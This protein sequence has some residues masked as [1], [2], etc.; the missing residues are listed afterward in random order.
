MKEVRHRRR[1]SAWF[2]LNTVPRQGKQIH[3]LEYW[4]P[5]GEWGQW[6]G[7]G[8]SGGHW[9]LSHLLFLVSMVAGCVP[10]D[11]SWSYASMISIVSGMYAM[12]PIAN[13]ILWLY[14]FWLISPKARHSGWCKALELRTW[15]HSPDITSSSLGDPGQGTTS[16]SVT[17]FIC[18]LA[19]RWKL[20]LT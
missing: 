13:P 15:M 14:P 18:R 12:L 2:C 6:P 5:L 7:I 17:F 9:R 1:N 10:L 19:W 11:N 4:F 3:K 20:S 16:L 8:V